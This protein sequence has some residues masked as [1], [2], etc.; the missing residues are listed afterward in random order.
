MPTMQHKLQRV[1]TSTGA[2]G[3]HDAASKCYLHKGMQTLKGLA[4]MQVTFACCMLQHK[5]LKNI[6]IIDHHIQP[7]PPSPPPPH[8]ASNNRTTTCGSRVNALVG[9]GK[10]PSAQVTIGPPH[11]AVE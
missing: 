1:R 9:S 6:Y 2:I 10:R 8:S 3:V 11:V 7:P 5:Y 4:L